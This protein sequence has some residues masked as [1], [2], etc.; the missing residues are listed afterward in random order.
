MKS[1]MMFCKDWKSNVIF[2]GENYFFR[3][4]F[5][6]MFIIKLINFDEIYY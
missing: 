5:W 6:G 4:Q 1:E 2:V 3:K